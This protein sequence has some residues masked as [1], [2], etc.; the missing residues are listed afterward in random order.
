VEDNSSDKHDHLVTDINSWQFYVERYERAKAVIDDVAAKTFPGSPFNF[1]MGR[2]QETAPLITSQYGP[3]GAGA[4]DRDVSWGFHF[5]TNELRLHEKIQ[6]YVYTQLTDVEWEHNGFYNY[7]RS[8]KEFGYDALVP[9]MT[10]RD[11]QGEDF[12]G[13][14]GPPVVRAT[15]FTLPV[16]VSHFSARTD[17]PTL[18]WW[19]TGFDD[20]GTAVATPPQ[21]QP[22]QWERAR[23]TSGVNL[24]VR[25]PESRPFAG[26]LAMELL[27]SAGQRIAANFVDIATRYAASPRVE[28]VDPRTV[29]L[30]FAPTAFSEPVAESGKRAGKFWAAKQADVSYRV[31]LPDWVASADPEQIEVL[32]E[33][34]TRAGAAKLDWPALRRP[35]DYPQTDVRKYPG[36]VRILISGVDAGEV[37]LPDDPADIRGFLSSVA[38]FHHASYGYLARVSA[39]APKGATELIVRILATNGVSIYGEGMGR[40]GFDPVVLVHTRQEVRAAH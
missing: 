22:V 29:A 12:V 36:K 8:A 30:R 19:L 10:V 23:V 1:I 2:T 25:V 3:L 37:S 18:R 38:G 11:L 4:G 39:A 32:A 40:Y 14:D 5:L 33:I 7:D 15:Q 27:D 13:Y 9:G 20:F 24:E 21:T 28:V 34:G 16:F 26:A 35:V 31:T 17:Q 6:G